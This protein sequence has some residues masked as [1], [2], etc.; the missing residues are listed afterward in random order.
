MVFV[1]SAW[2]APLT[3]QTK[4]DIKQ[5]IIYVLCLTAVSWLG[6]ISVKY[7]RKVAPESNFIEPLFI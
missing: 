5:T 6:F 7:L 1:A 4:M 2:Y 3:N